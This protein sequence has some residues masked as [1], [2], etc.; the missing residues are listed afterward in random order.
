MHQRQ[1][2]FTQRLTGSDRG[3][4][5]IEGDEA[6]LRPQTLK[7]RKAVAAATKGA[8]H[9]DAIGLD[10]E[11]SDGLLQQNGD[12]GIGYIHSARFSKPG[13]SPVFISAS[14]ASCCWRQPASDQSSK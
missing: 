10:L 1:P 12:V 3:R 8:V 7:H 13:G 2:C 11:C 6:P 9:I 14:I 5:A 4:I